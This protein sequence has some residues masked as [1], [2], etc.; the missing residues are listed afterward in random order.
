MI[1]IWVTAQIFPYLPNRLRQ[2]PVYK[3][4]AVPQRSRLTLKQTQVMQ[5]LRYVSALVKN[6]LVLRY[7]FTIH[8]HNYM[9]R[10][11]SDR[12]MPPGIF[13]GNAV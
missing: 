1:P 4:A 10:V 8:C 7:R 2:F 5:R 13:A 12:Y 6:T 9:A 3:R 11:F